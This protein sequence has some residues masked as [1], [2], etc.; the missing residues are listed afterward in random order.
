M[1]V[2]AQSP[3]YIPADTFEYASPFEGNADLV[4]KSVFDRP[5]QLTSAQVQGMRQEHHWQLHKVCYRTFL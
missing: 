4:L 1:H 5:V 3:P 2:Q